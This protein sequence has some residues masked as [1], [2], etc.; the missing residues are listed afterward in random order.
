M[1]FGDLEHGCWMGVLTRGNIM[2]ISALVVATPYYVLKDGM[3]PIGPRLAISESMGCLAIFGFSSKAPYDIFCS[4]SSASLAP[5]PLVKDYLRN[6]VGISGEP[7]ENEEC[8][9]LVILDAPGPCESSLHAA[10][11]EDVLQA[12]E[13]R[14]T[15]MTPTHHLTFNAKSGKYHLEE[16]PD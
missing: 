16:G 6:Q 11:M 7:S 8:L 4:E 5:Y 10:T 1:C 12:Q 14:T 9:K 2:Q 3:T 13:N 15:R